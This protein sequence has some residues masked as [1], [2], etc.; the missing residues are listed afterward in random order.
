MIDSTIMPH[1]YFADQVF[2]DSKTIEKGNYEACRFLNCILPNSDLS[3][4]KFIECEF[5]N[6]DFSSSTLYDTS[7]NNVF[8]KDCKL[9]GLR[10]ENCNSF[11][12]SI[13]FKRCNLNLSSFFQMNPKSISFRNCNLKEV[14][15]S[16]A[17]LIETVFE[18]CDLDSAIF[19]KSNLRKTDFRSSYNF[20][21]DPQ[22]NNIQQAKF[23][24]QGLPGLLEKYHLDIE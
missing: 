13:D 15:F 9:L 24:L 4:V 17:N 18:N 10:F 19:K 23:S 7:F 20:S 22:I 1:L 21:V 14:D 11:L 5:E 2:K 3:E 16:E 12:F 8:F 6:C